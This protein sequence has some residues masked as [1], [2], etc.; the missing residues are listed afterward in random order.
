MSTERDI[1]ERL[2]EPSMRSLGGKPLPDG[3]Y[4]MGCQCD[5]GPGP[6]CIECTLREDPLRKEAAAEIER[7]RGDYKRLLEGFENYKGMYY[8]TSRRIDFYKANHKRQKSELLSAR[9]V[10]AA[11]KRRLDDWDS[12]V[13]D[14]RAACYECEDDEHT[15][16]I[17]AALTVHEAKYPDSSEVAADEEK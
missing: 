7:L 6:T 17:R 9:A 5:W 4:H 15:A 12:Q 13:S 3:G 1:V 14:P 2:T 10:I 16:A 8:S 11:A